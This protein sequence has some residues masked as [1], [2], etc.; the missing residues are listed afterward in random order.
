MRGGGGEEEGG[1]G[2]GGVLFPDWVPYSS[3]WKN[4][5]DRYIILCMYIIA[6]EMRC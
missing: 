5:S 6:D 1:G 4:L 3:D 2:G